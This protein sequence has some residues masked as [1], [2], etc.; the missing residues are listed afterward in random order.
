MLNPIK[1]IISVNILLGIITQACSLSEIDTNMKKVEEEKRKEKE[2]EKLNDGDEKKYRTII[3]YLA[4]NPNEYNEN[5]KTTIFNFNSNFNEFYP[6][7]KEELENVICNVLGSNTLDN[8]YVYVL[9]KSQGQ[10]KPQINP[11]SATS[12]SLNA[13]RDFQGQIAGRDN[14]NSTTIS[15]GTVVMLGLAVLGI[16]FVLKYSKQ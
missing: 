5:Y 13:G 2:K 12:T 16:I 1:K 3:Q 10:R 7:K 9:E 8:A 6:S 14:I 11:E 4:T 15:G